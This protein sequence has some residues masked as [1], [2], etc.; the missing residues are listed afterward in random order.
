LKK[1]ETVII[2][3]DR[4]IQDEGK[5]FVEEF[6]AKISRAGGEIVKVTSL[7]RK[8]FARQ[9]KK[10]KTGFYWDF[11]INLDEK[12]AKKLPTYYN[13]DERVLRLQTFIYDR[14][15]TPVDKDTA[16][17]VEKEEQVKVSVSKE[18]E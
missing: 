17:T 14:P 1:Y 5:A 10:R 4:K 15:E 3:D 18:T 16:E 7:G 8:Q 6:S 9:M 11:T 2:L 13:L 12:E